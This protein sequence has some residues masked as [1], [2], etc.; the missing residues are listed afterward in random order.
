[1]D[2]GEILTRAVVGWSLVRSVRSSSWTF[3]VW[4][5]F[6]A[7][8]CST[9][10]RSISLRRRWISPFNCSFSPLIIS[11]VVSF[12]KAWQRWSNGTIDSLRDLHFSDQLEVFL[13][14]FA[15][16]VRSLSIDF[17]KDV[18]REEKTPQTINHSQYQPCSCAVDHSHVWA[19]RNRLGEIAE[20]FAKKNN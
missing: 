5:S 1:M 9:F 10:S 8:W 11:R 19:Q 15:L 4:I 13:L 17:P 20:K 7:V 18:S 6:A 14:C 2:S 16:F 3:K 12:C